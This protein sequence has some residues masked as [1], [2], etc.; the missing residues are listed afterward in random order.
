MKVRMIKKYTVVC[1]LLMLTLATPVIA[2]E[3]TK[4][5]ALINADSLSY[6]KDKKTAKAVGN[7]E[8]TQGK[9]ML[10]ADE[11]T[12]SQAEN[13]VIATGNVS[14]LNEDGSTVFADHMELKDDM[15]SGFLTKLKARLSDKSLLV[16]EKGERIDEDTYVLHDATYTPCTLCKDDKYPLWQVRAKKITVDQKDQWMAYK[17]SRFEVYGVPVFYTPYFGHATPDADRKTGLLP[18]SYS[19]SGTLGAIAKVPLYVNIAG[20][21]DA[22]ITP[23]LTSKEGTVLSGEYRHAVSNGRYELQGSITRPSKIDGLGNKIA[24]SDIRGHI[25]GKGNF[26]LDNL[27]SWGFDAKRSTDDTYLRRYQFGYEDYLTSHIYAERINNRDYFSARALS[28]QGLQADD[29]ASLTPFVLPYLSSH[30]ERKTGYK[31]SV[32]SLDQ[33]FVAITRD[34]GTKSARLTNDLAWKLPYITD[35]GHVLKLTTSVRGD[36]YSVDDFVTASNKEANNFSGRLVPSVQV[37]WSYPVVAKINNNPWL[38]E[39]IAN[40]IIAPHG[41]NPDDLP[42]ED[43]YTLE[44]SDYNLFSNN[45]FSGVDRI[46]SGP[47]ANYGMKSSFHYGDNLNTH[48]LFGQTYH[49][50]GDNDNTVIGNLDDNFSDYVGHVKINSGDLFDVAYRFQI[51]KNDFS[52]LQREVNSRLNLNPFVFNVDYVF[53][54]DRGLSSAISNE[55]LAS[56][57]SY[58]INERWAV[59]ANGRHDLSEDGGLLYNGANIH[60]NGD[61][62]D[63]MVSWFRDFIRDRDIEPS[64]SITFQISLKNL[65]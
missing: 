28:F 13:T 45:R 17:H 20:N 12:Y 4:Q 30:I 56:S 41:G 5:P 65:N 58:N 39:P 24:G 37:D 43:S 63:F 52:P 61:C 6:D 55:Q 62:A 19:S 27:W 64:T 9:R 36:V 11:V 57:A 29:D 34:Q 31:N 51:D 14:L 53:L 48:F 35:G 10:I 18:P 46:E 15:K 1:S 22:T 49:I 44:L 60:Y 42:N 54:D 2:D 59:S 50:K 47:R 8:I 23:I 16:S 26:V 21:M 38:V 32:W 25:E 33:S 40:V 3:S 7:V